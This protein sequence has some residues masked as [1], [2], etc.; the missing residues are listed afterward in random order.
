MPLSNVMHVD[1]PSYTRPQQ[2]T[3]RLVKP[4]KFGPEVSFS[5]PARFSFNPLATHPVVDDLIVRVDKA[6]RR[7]G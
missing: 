5:P 6:R 3:L 4:G 7:R 1:G 2:I